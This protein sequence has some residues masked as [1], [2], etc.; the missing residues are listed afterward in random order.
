MPKRASTLTLTYLKEVVK[1]SL[2]RKKL[3]KM[4]HLYSDHT[5]FPRANQIKKNQEFP[6]DIK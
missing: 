6:K 5:Q 2:I 4:K 1:I 3:S